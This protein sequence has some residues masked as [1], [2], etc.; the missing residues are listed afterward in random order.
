MGYIYKITNFINGKTYVGSTN[1][2]LNHRWNIH[3]SLLRRHIHGNKH[4][5]NSWN[6]YGESN[7]KFDMIEECDNSVLIEREEYNKNLLFS[8]YNLAPITE[9]FGKLNKGRKL[10]T[11]HKEK[12]SRGNIGKILSEEHKK[13]LIQSRI[14][15]HHSVETK[16]KISSSRKGKLLGIPK[17]PFSEI[18][19]K[20]LSVSHIG[21]NRGESHYNFKGKYIFYHPNY[22]EFIL[23]QCEWSRK[24][25]KGK[26]GKIS[27]ICLGKRKSYRGWICKGKL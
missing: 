8:E 6:K 23:G 18:H 5:Q 12:I 10:T 21:V 25:N 2:K 19:L 7:F 3:K 22:G 15:T 11:E 9:S 16:L 4:L 24:Y 26:Q 13:I 17:P 14:G 27:D 20:N 1:G